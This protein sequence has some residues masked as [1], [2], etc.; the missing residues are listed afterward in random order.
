LAKY[1]RLYELGFVLVCIAAH[2]IADP[3][4]LYLLED[5]NMD[6]VTDPYVEQLDSEYRFLK[7]ELEKEV[8]K[9]ELIRKQHTLKTNELADLL[10]RK[11]FELQTAKLEARRNERG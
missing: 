7:V 4:V 1:W 5:C 6:K 10:T 11:F 3:D 2:G 8:N 9:F